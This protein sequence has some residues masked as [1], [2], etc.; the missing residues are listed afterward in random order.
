MNISIGQNLTIIF[1]LFIKIHDDFG[2]PL[3]RK[4]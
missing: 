2:K 4:N 3:G 1:L